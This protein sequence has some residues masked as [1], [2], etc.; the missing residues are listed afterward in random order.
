MDRIILLSGPMASG[1]STLA[2]Q[3]VDQFGMKLFQTRKWLNAKIASESEAGR[4]DLQEEGEDLDRQTNGQWVKDGLQK[5]LRSG[6]I[7]GAIVLDAVRTA[8]QIRAI[9]EAYG[10]IVTHVHVSASPEVL[11]ERYE[12]RQ[13]ESATSEDLA[14]YAEAREN[15]TERQ[16]DSLKGIADVSID[17]ERSTQDDVLVRV[18]SHLRLYGEQ[19]SGYVDVIV[20]GQYGSEGKGQ[21]A[22]YLANE[23][24]LLVRVGGPNAG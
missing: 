20:G 12:T 14:P 1:K 8:E 4:I 15:E 2:R 18:A 5:E 11:A 9:R 24:D 13:R 21:I 6:G 22:A 17:T 23:Y 19:D 7:D 16:V 10:P 3:L